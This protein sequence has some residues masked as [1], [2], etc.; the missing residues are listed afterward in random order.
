MCTKVSIVTIPKKIDKHKEGRINLMAGERHG[1]HALVEQ[2]ESRNVGML[3]QAARKL[4]R[5]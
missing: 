2:V 1:A 4:I 3:Q 5:V